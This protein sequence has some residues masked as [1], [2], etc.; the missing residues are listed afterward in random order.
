[1]KYIACI[2]LKEGI[3][4]K[5]SSPMVGVDYHTLSSGLDYVENYLK[6]GIKDF[7]VFGSTDNKSIDFASEDGLIKHFIRSAKD[8]FKDEVI[9]HADVGLSPYSKD[10]HSTVI[11]NGEINYE[12]SYALVSKLAV[13]FAEAGADYIAPCLSLH[14]QVEVLRNVLDQ[15]G[16]QKTKIHAYSSKFSS[17]LYGPYRE[18][19]QSPLK[20]Q[21]KKAYQVDYANPEEALSQIKVD[22]SQSADIVMVKPAMIYL[23]IVYRARQLTKLPLSVYHVSGEYTMIKEACKTGMLNENETFDEVHSAF[24]RCGVNYVIGYAPDHFIR[25]SKK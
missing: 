20:A 24:N 6:K 18:T 19:I 15:A 3:T 12:K 4:E 25:W 9:M 2:F 11:E 14:E 8:K 7:L 1:M 16:Y 17:A 10:G 13:A 5:Q 21:D 23:D 22:E